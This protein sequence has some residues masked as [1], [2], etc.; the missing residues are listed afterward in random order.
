MLLKESVSVSC[1][2]VRVFF[3]WVC[4]FLSLLPLFH[5]VLSS[6]GVGVGVGV[7]IL[8]CIYLIFYFFSRV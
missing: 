4:V 7:L 3:L 6:T 8:T 2:T 5:N 1:Y